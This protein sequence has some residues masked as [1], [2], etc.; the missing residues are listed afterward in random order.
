MCCHRTL[1]VEGTCRYN[2]DKGFYCQV[3]DDDRFKCLG[4]G[5]GRQ[6][7]PMQER[8]AKYLAEY[9]SKAN[10]ALLKLL[11]KSGQLIPGWLRDSQV[12]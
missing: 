6:Y 10:A 1:H 8:T 2:A 3:V 9:Y 7:P 12:S 4:S 11:E 5:K